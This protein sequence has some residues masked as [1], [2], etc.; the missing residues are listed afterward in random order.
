MRKKLL[1]AAAA[2]AVLA[3]MLGT[4]TQA[5]TAPTALAAPAVHAAPAAPVNVGT[6][7]AKAAHTKTLWI[8]RSGCTWLAY[9][10]HTGAH[11]RKVQGGC[12]GHSW[13]YVQS[14]TGWKSGWKS[15]WKHARGQAGVSMQS[16]KGR[17][18]VKYSWH[19][20]RRNETAR[21]IAH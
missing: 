18:K 20:T 8:R 11:T 7:T 21:L 19:K 13:I 14:T 2:S 4:P 16:P 10:S 15:G 17:G 5:S 3:P 6:F 12:T 9:S 1:V